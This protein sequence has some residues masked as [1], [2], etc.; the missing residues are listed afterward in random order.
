MGTMFIMTSRKS[1]TEMAQTG[2]RRFKEDESEKL[3]REV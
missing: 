2:R 1:K 3:D